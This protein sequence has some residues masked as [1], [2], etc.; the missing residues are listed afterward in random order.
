[1]VNIWLQ[2]FEFCWF[3]GPDKE[4]WRD[5]DTIVYGDDRLTRYPILPEN[6]KERVIHLYKSVFGM[7]IK[8]EKIKTSETLEGLTFC[9]FTV[10]PDRLPYPTD[11]EKLYA[12]LVTPAR[13]LP[14]VTALHE[15]L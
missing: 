6:Y 14:D 2:A 13:K 10:G 7:W 11:E 12:G 4:L 9:G 3:F 1:M 15:K 5:Y 8:P